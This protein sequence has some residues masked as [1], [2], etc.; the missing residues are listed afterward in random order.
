MSTPLANGF[1]QTRLM[2]QT[3][4]ERI[5]TALS[6]QEGILRAEAVPARHIDSVF[7]WFV[8]VIPAGP[9]LIGKCMPFPINDGARAR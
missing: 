6:T 9:T 3:D 2:R 8:L 5:A 7:D 4:A 1:Y